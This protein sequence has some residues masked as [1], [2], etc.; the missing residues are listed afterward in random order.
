[1]EWPSNFLVGGLIILLSSALLLLLLRRTNYSRNR[2]PQG[3]PGWPIIGNMLDLGT[4]PHRTLADLRK[5]YGHV[6]WLRLGTINTMVIL[7]T[8]A[9]TEFF[10]NHDICFAER[11][12]TET[13]RVHGYDKGSL[14]LAPYGSYWRVLRRLVT[15]DMLVIKR[16]NESAS[17][18][19]KCADDMLLW[20]EEEGR[21]VGD[22]TGIHV[23]RFVF[24]ATFNLLGNLMLSR[25]LLNP[26][27]KD[28]ANFFAA[29][30]GLMEWSGYANV[31]DYF[32]W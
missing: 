16:I 9:S 22:A 6:I 8:K 12:T 7:S 25:D 32:P 11:F 14:A 20:I 23:A 2:L 29:M 4:M 13:M 28:G 21:K 10:K 1:M 26:D 17:I 27:S 15:V 24:L 18:R 31:A 19:R 30:M 5:K 3:P